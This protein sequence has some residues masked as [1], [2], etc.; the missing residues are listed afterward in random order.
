MNTGLR[1]FEKRAGGGAIYRLNLELRAANAVGGPSQDSKNHGTS[2][3]WRNALLRN[4]IIS[5]LYYGKIIDYGN[6]N[7]IG[8][9]QVGF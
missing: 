6:V 4:G 3:S 2:F 9:C 5:V 7:N 1:R 8:N